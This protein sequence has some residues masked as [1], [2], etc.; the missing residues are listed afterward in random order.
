[1]ATFVCLEC[2]NKFEME[3]NEVVFTN[4]WEGGIT[5]PECGILLELET[6]YLKVFKKLGADPYADPTKQKDSKGEKEK[7]KPNPQD[8]HKIS[9]AIE[10][11]RAMQR[12][13][14]EDPEGY[15]R[16]Y[17]DK[18]LPELMRGV[19]DFLKHLP[20]DRRRALNDY[21]KQEISEE[22]EYK[23]RQRREMFPKKYS[24]ILRTAKAQETLGKELVVKTDQ[25]VRF[26]TKAQAPSV[27]GKKV[28]I[29]AFIQR[30]SRATS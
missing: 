11:I 17:G 20:P 8:V 3:A 21:I 16:R 29:G 1:M 26:V 30:L 14:W 7:K 15:K 4:L 28:P 27:A 22:P 25:G 6:G 9:T 10:N 13:R 2:Q 24:R 18:K 12:K 5:C 19:K 23:I